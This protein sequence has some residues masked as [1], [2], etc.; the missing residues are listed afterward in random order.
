MVATN[1]LVRIALCASLL[2]AL[3]AHAA[4][5]PP[6][7][8]PAKSAPSGDTLPLI[9]G[10]LVFTNPNPKVWKLDD[11]SAAPTMGMIMFKRDPIMNPEGIPIWP[12]LAVVYE[13][14]PKDSKMDVIEYS[15]F[16]RQQLPFDVDRVLTPDSGDLTYR[17]AI[18]YEG[19]QDQHGRTHKLLIAHM[20]FD[21]QGIVVIGDATADVYDK[22]AGEMKAFLKSVDAK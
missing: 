1:V 6:K 10:K 12:V 7:P 19:H 5:E 20:L 18:G 2:L 22:V 11:R 14:L 3:P 9:R 17:N 16:K 8:D 13:D 15:L 4:E 21:H